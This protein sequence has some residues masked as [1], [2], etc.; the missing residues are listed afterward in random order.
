MCGFK[1]VCIM[2][3]YKAASLCIGVLSM[4]WLP[5]MF[6]RFFAV[7]RPQQQ[8]GGADLLCITPAALRNRQPVFS[9]VHAPTTEHGIDKA[10]C[11]ATQKARFPQCMP[12]QLSME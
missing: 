1:K 4:L 7:F 3:P 2:P 6:I 5:S 9:A 10:R 11:P 8:T 12:Q